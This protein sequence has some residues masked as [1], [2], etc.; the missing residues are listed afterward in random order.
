MR[1]VT[2]KILC[3]WA[4]ICL[5]IPIFPTP[6]ASAA[7]LHSGYPTY[8]HNSANGDVRIYWENYNI[9]ASA[10]PNIYNNLTAGNNYW[11]NGTYTNCNMTCIKTTST[12]ST[13]ATNGRVYHIIPSQEWWNDNTGA[14]PC[15]VTGRA[16]NFDTNLVQ[17]TAANVSTTTRRIY[18]SHLYYPPDTS[19]YTNLNY[20]TVNYRCTIAHEIGHAL[21]FGHMLSGETVQYGES[22]MS[23]GKKSLTALNPHYDIPNFNAK[24]G[25]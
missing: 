23:E 8:W 21:G 1:N 4:A 16:V 6:T 10:Y 2:R 7:E 17:I 11:D 22:I 14:T 25:N 19:N 12:V 15:Q 3:L 20:G 9:T 13:S 5:C 18:I 24:Y